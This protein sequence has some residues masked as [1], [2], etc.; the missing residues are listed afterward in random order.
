MGFSPIEN[1]QTEPSFLSYSHRTLWKNEENERFL[2]HPSQSCENSRQLVKRMIESGYE[3]RMFSDG[4]RW[5]CSFSK[6]E[7]HHG[8]SKNDNEA[9]CFAALQAHNSDS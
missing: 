9:I 7:I 2:F 8:V 3:F 1:N 6:E 5:I 4:E